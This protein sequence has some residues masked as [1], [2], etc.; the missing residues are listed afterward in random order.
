MED[1]IILKDPERH[2]AK[3]LER[4]VKEEKKEC[5]NLGLGIK[6]LARA[7]V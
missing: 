6:D 2:K 1:R 4:S 7:C 3:L 5:R